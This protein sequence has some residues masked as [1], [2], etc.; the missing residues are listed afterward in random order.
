[1]IEKLKKKKSIPSTGFGCTIDCLCKVFTCILND[2]IIAKLEIYG[3]EIH[4]SGQV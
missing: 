1:M 4:G 3:F 2:L